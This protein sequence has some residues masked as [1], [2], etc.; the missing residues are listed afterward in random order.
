MKSDSYSCERNEYSVPV[1]RHGVT[2]VTVNGFLGRKNVRRL[3]ACFL[4]L[5]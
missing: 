2:G 1:N 3:R 5:G 4:N